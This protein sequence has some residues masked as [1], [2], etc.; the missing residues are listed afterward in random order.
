MDKERF[1]RSGCFAVPKIARGWMGFWSDFRECRFG[2]MAISEDAMRKVLDGS[3]FAFECGLVYAPVL[4]FYNGAPYG[5]LSRAEWNGPSH[6][7]TLCVDDLDRELYGLLLEWRKVYRAEGEESRRAS[8]TRMAQV[9]DEMV[10][11]LRR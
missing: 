1:F 2:T 10:G 4:I 6:L 9:R 3:L 7:Y 8:I 11:R 5:Y